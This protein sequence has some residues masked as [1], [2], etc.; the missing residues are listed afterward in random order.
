MRQYCCQN[1]K[2]CDHIVVKILNFVIRLLSKLWIMWSDCCQNYKCCDQIF[3]KIGC[4]A[5]RSV[6]GD[7]QGNRILQLLQQIPIILV[8]NDFAAS[9]ATNPNNFLVTDKHFHNVRHLYDKNTNK[10]K[11]SNKST[12]IFSFILQVSI[13]W[14]KPFKTHV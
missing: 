7:N 8:R 14:F 5:P 13:V 6:W 1:Y 3:Y 11:R 9:P 10:Q 4:F 12:P 2:H